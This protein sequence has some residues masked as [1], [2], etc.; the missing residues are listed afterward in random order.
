MPGLRFKES[1]DYRDELSRQQEKQIRRMYGDLARKVAQEARALEGVEGSAY[2]R[3]QQLEIL[4]RQ[5]YQAQ[6][7]IT[8]RL[9]GLIPENMRKV[10]AGLT[11]ETSDFLGALG[12]RKPRAMYSNVPDEVVSA[13]ISGKLYQ[14]KDG[15]PW[16]LSGAIWGDNAK[17]KKD[18]NTVIAEGIAQN[19]SSY[20]IA[21]ALEQYIDPA[22]KKPWDWSKVYPGTKKVIDYNV[23][24]LSR[25]MVSHAYQA[26]FVSTTKSNPF[27]SE[28][29]WHS[30]LIHGR[31]CPVCEDLDQ[32]HFAKD[33]LPLDHPNGLCWWEAYIPNSLDDVAD[34]IA[35][36]YKYGNDPELDVFADQVYSRATRSTVNETAAEF[37]RRGD[38]NGNR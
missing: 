3:Q 5:L 27:V 34:R 19:K 13:V 16:S 22:A 35:N 18:I 12:M 14:N 28:Y 21:K 23:Q 29:I 10:V 37:A 8:A 1:E 25:T 33:S 6:D 32:Q 36:W 2:L 31:T 30:A 15:S 7:G 9:A 38:V 4:S 24:R 20:D 11:R 26:A 17:T